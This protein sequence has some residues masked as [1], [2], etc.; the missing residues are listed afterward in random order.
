MNYKIDKEFFKAFLLKHSRSD[1]F[2]YNYISDLDKLVEESYLANWFSWEVVFNHE[3]N[4][5]D[6]DFTKFL[7]DWCYVREY[8][9]SFDDFE[10]AFIYYL[11]YQLCSKIE[12]YQ[13]Q[14]TI[15]LNLFCTSTKVPIYEV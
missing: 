1:A 15:L 14:A 12:V 5:H 8:F 10:T 13:E 3:L 7:N 11:K 2:F 9:K 4:L 6:V